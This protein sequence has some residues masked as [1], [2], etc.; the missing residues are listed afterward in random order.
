MSLIGV[1]HVATMTDDLDRLIDFYKRI[2]KSKIVLDVEI[3]QIKARHAFITI[4]GPSILHAWEVEDVDTGRFDGEMFSRGRI[5]HIALQASSQASFETFRDRL[6][7]EGATEG[8]INDF[9]VMESF[10][11]RD[12]DGL[13]CEV[14]WYKGEPD[15][16]VMDMSLF[17]DPIADA[18]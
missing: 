15:P 16:S 11:F 17:R 5:D 18:L 1:N 14:C 10:S 4:G 12:P 7:A 8:V 6:L 2:F 9:G 13:W 3:P